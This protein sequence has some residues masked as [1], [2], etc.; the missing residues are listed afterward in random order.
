MLDRR[1]PGPARTQSRSRRSE[2]SLR[3]LRPFWRSPRIVPSPRRSRS[4][5]AS[6]KP[7]VVSTSASSRASPSAVAGAD[8]V[9][10]RLAVRAPADPAPQLVELRDAE[11][12][13]VEDHHH[14]RVGHVDA[15]LDHGRRDEHVELAGAEAA[16]SP[17]PSRADVIRPCSRP[18]RRPA[19]L[20]GAAA[21][22]RSPRSPSATSS[23]S[24]SSISGHTTY[25]WRPAATSSRTRP[26]AL[27]RRRRARVRPHRSR[28]ASARRQL[29]EHRHVE[30]AV[31]G[32]RRGARDRGGRHHQHVGDGAVGALRAQRRP[33]LDAEAVLLVDHHDAERRKRHPPRSAALRADQRC[34]PR[35]SASPASMPRAL[36]RSSGS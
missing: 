14:R 8:Q 17:P 36:G 27:A 6:S 10:P 35:P 23:F 5:S 32:H 13:G 20:A 28:S 24:D 29:V 18:S 21:G 9:A 15:D 7:S 34:R 2:A 16:P 25:A 19:E 33:L 3:S 12:V 4:T 11:A 1:P 26:H 30:V 22:R 31:D